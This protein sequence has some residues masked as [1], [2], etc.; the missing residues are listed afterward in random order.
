MNDHEYEIDMLRDQVDRSADVIAE[1]RDALATIY[2]MNG[3]D[4]QIAALCD[5]L[6]TKYETGYRP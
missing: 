6:L 4:P 3:E 2:A 1:L 5:P